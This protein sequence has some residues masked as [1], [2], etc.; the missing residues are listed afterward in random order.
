MLETP[1]LL[2]RGWRDSDV[3]PLVQM[4]ADPRVNAFLY[5]TYTREISQA[6][7]ERMR[8][9]LARAG[10]GWWVVEVRNGPAFA[11]MVCVREV[12]FEARFT[13]TWE[14][15]WRFAFDAWGHGYATEAARAALDFAFGRLG[16]RE[17]VA[18]TSESN[19]RSQRVM[20]RL[21][22][23][24]DPADDFDHPLIE[25][26]HALRRHVLYRLRGAQAGA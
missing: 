2:L 3:E 9:E 14:I 4:N 20:V 25:E 24:H 5:R 17:I 13:P 18:F 23:T 10:Y 26:E 8:E 16:L 11:G 12:P 22:M 15:G 7:V 19:L 6:A 1:R 21:G